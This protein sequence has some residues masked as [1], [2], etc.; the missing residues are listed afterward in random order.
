MKKLKIS[1]WYISKFWAPLAGGPNVNESLL[2]MN[3]NNKINIDTIINEILKPNLE[4]FDYRYKINFK[5]SFKCAIS[6]YSDKEL[7]DSF[8]NSQPQIDLPNNLPVRDFYIQVWFILYGNES[9]LP[10][11]KECYTEISLE[12]IFN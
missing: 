8:Y 9:Y 1:Y 4:L 11:D 6:Y 2:R 7:I 5:N 3:L 12:D 10:L